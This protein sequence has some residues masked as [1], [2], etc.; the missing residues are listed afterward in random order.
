MSQKIKAVK[1]PI[2]VSAFQ[3]DKAIDI[4]TLEGTMHANPGDWVITGPEG[5]RWPVKREIFERTYK[6][7]D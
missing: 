6:V 5:E 4:K 3:T 7:L 1:K 2:P